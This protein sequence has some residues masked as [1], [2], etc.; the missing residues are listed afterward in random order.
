MV[1]LTFKWRKATVEDQLEIAKLALGQDESS[2]RLSLRCELIVTR[3]IA[4]EQVLEDTSV[5]G[6]RH[7]V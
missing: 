6:V 7:F 5:R 1:S 3:G 2:E 4:G